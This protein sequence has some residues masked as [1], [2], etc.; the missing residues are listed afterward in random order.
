MASF[1]VVDAVIP[2]EINFWA[3]AQRE[4]GGRVNN[5]QWWTIKI[6]ISSLVK[7]GSLVEVKSI[8][9]IQKNLGL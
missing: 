7:A 9:E 2:Y 1:R 3:A 5:D 4:G 6:T 8:Q